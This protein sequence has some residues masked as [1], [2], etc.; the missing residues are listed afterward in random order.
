MNQWLHGS[1]STVSM[2]TEIEKLSELKEKGILTADEF[3][4]V[5][6]QLLGL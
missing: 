2:A 1:N 4:H 5:K 6:R 3:Q